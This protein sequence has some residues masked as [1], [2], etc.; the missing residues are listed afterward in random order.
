M[1]GEATAK[2]VHKPRPATIGGI[3]RGETV[4]NAENLNGIIHE[5]LSVGWEDFP[6]PQVVDGIEP[7]TPVIVGRLPQKIA[8]CSKLRRKAQA[9]GRGQNHRH[10]RK[11]GKR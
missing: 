11:A 9:C 4:R 7:N 5:R 8:M 3:E 1:I 2:R 10:L 6:P